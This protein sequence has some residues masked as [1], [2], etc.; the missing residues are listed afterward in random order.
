[1]VSKSKVKEAVIGF[2][3]SYNPEKDFSFEDRSDRAHLADALVDH[4]EEQQMLNLT[5]AADVEEPDVA[6]SESVE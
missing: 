3:D 2:F 5:D 6:E 4:L 1:M